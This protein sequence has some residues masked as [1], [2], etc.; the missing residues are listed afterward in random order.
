MFDCLLPCIPRRHYQALGAAGQAA[1]EELWAAER[2]R[3]AISFLEA[4]EVTSAE[5]SRLLAARRLLVV[6]SCKSAA[7]ALIAIGGVAKSCD[8]AAKGAVKA[9]ERAAR[10]V[11]VLR[12][13]SQVE[14][15]DRRAFIAAAERAFGRPLTRESVDLCDEDRELK[16]LLTLT[17]HKLRR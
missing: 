9:A 16:A 10:D 17:Y 14:P 13:L 4:A 2:T 5:A 8:R 3:D 7:C 11:A 1:P 12:C 6:P 15:G